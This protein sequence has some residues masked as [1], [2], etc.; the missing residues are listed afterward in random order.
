MTSESG[1]CEN[2]ILWISITMSASLLIACEG[3]TQTLEAPLSLSM[4]Q[5]IAADESIT[6]LMSQMKA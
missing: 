3:Q 4:I 1:E 2:K 5:S 6:K